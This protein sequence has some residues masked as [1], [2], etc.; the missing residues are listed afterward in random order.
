[1]KGGRG[2]TPRVFVLE[3]QLEASRRDNS[4]TKAQHVSLLAR[5]VDEGDKE[6]NPPLT[7][8]AAREDRRCWRLGV[9]K[10]DEGDKEGN[11]PLMYAAREGQLEATEVLVEL[12]ADAAAT[13]LNDVTAVHAAADKGYTEVVTVLIN[14]GG[15]QSGERRNVPGSRARRGW[16]VGRPTLSG[17]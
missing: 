3:G 9:T 7:L 11:Q 6:G 10:V 13:N 1:M 4:V 5:Q 16:S 12:E 14:A 8:Y 17:W 15:T 2:G